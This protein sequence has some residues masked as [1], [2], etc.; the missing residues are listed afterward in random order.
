MS[1]VMFYVQNSYGTGHL[2][3]VLNLASGLKHH[4]LIVYGGDEFSVELPD[5]SFHKLPELHDSKKGLESKEYSLEYVKKTR[6]NTL[7]SLFSHFEPD[8]LFIEHFPFGRAHF[9]FEIEPL[10]NLAKQN[11][12]KIISSF[13]GIIGKNIDL[14]QLEKDINLF[15]RI[16]IHTDE[17][18]TI[19]ETQLPSERIVYTGYIA[20]F[21]QPREKKGMI[22][23]V[24][25]GRDADIILEKLDSYEIE[26]YKGPYSKTSKSL[27]FT[28]EYNTELKSKIAEAEIV[29][30]TAGY[31]S[32][33]EAVHANC[34]TILIPIN[35]EQRIRAENFEK[36]ALA[37]YILP[38]ELTQKRL[39]ETIQNVS[40][41]AK[42]DMSGVEF[43][44]DFLSK[45][46]IQI[47]VDDM[48]YKNLG[49]QNTGKKNTYM[50][51]VMFRY[52]GNASKQ[53]F[54]ENIAPKIFSE[55]QK[56][57]KKGFSVSGLDYMTK[58]ISK[59]DASNHAMKK[60]TKKENLI[61]NI[62]EFQ[63]EKIA[64]KSYPTNLYIELTRN[65]NSLCQMCARSFGPEEF[66]SYSPL[67]NMDFEFFK[68]IA[69]ELFPTALEVDLRGF[70]ESTILPDIEKYIDY[71]LKFSTQ[72]ILVT[73]LTKKDDKLWEKL[74]KNK[75]IIGIS[76]D[77]A[78][79]TVYEK[80]RRGSRFDDV[81]HNLKLVSDLSKKYKNN[82]IFLMVCVQ[83]DNL[84][85]IHK[86]VKL[87]AKL[88]ISE[89][90][91]NPVGKPEFSTN[92]LPKEKVRK[93]V[94][95]CISIAKENRVKLTMS[96]SF[97]LGRVEKQIQPKLQ[98]K[99]PRPWSYAYI[100]YDG[101]LGP[102]NHRFNPPLVF[103]DLKKKN[104]AESWNSIGFKVFRGTI[105]SEHRFGKCNWC[106]ENRYF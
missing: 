11:K 92:S 53:H 44:N 105:H 7:F 79:K 89:V 102:C 54:F 106:Y 13:R 83:K 59:Q 55:M 9:R 3:M 37:K 60:L 17:N 62:S 63:Q 6:L 103:S 56:Y 85:E 52:D 15:D 101:K 58:L 16:L 20:P 29:I 33:I 4:A 100:T 84:S 40:R 8:F 23:H 34:K 74:I 99:C 39:M 21:F 26:T 51:E 1:K 93:E 96:G 67:H 104:F 19:P 76:F 94:I 47:V 27:K 36:A 80:I 28:K 64:L 86:I 82:N 22:A 50:K 18:V 91:L 31:N 35:K 90:E 2:R 45:Y 95:K 10:I 41:P 71:A 98:G 14:A 24:G 65:C 30:C 68:R 87:A 46:P 66:K 61:L 88:N 81:M 69:D 70:G 75:F 43:V 5:V 57:K 72:Y 77:G 12:T 32:V 38:E 49:F 97:G 78:T 48:N 25:S 42:V 73:N